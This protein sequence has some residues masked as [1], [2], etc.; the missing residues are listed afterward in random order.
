M[1]KN[2]RFKY[3]KKSAEISVEIDPR[4]SVNADGHAGDA[5]NTLYNKTRRNNWKKHAIK[6]YD[7][8]L[9]YYELNPDPKMDETI[10]IIRH[11]FN[12]LKKSK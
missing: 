8:F 1:N 2:G 5:A 4:H 9:K 11:N 7:I 6:H 3:E 12:Y 10:R